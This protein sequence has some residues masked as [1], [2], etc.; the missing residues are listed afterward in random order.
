MPDSELGAEQVHDGRGHRALVTGLSGTGKS[1]SWRA[2]A[3]ARERGSERVKEGGTEKVGGETLEMV[4][5]ELARRCDSKVALARSSLQGLPEGRGR[6]TPY[7]V[8]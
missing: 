7:L 4:A 5:C 1:R 3:S 6:D 8:R 2:G